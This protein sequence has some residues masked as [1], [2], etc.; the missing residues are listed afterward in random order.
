MKAPLLLPHLSRAVDRKQGAPPAWQAALARNHALDRAI[1][2]YLIGAHLDDLRALENTNSGKTKA[3]RS[4]PSTSTRAKRTRKTASSARA[5]DRRDREGGSWAD[6]VLHLLTGQVPRGQGGPADA[7]LDAITA[8]VREVTW[9]G[10]GG[11]GLQGRS[12]CGMSPAEAAEV[13]TEA[14]RRLPI[15]APATTFP[16]DLLDDDDDSMVND[17]VPWGS[18]GSEAGTRRAPWPWGPKA[19]PPSAMGAIVALAAALPPA[20]KL[21]AGVEV[22]L[23]VSEEVIAAAK[24]EAAVAAGEAAAASGSVIRGNV[25]T[26]A[27]SSVAA[28]GETHRSVEEAS[29]AAEQAL[30]LYISEYC[31]KDPHLWASVTEYVR[32]DG[33]R[34]EVDGSA[35]ASEDSAGQKLVGALLRRCGDELGGKAFVKA[36]PEELDLM[37]CL[38]EVERNLRG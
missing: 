1:L 36:L 28:V 5:R 32:H 27:S 10:N 16:G 21:L 26:G 12:G 19:V 15:T 3:A 20:G 24:A 2:R 14:K 33:D 7:H 34:Q 6:A 29:R 22:M 37:Q 4:T 9:Q 11:D 17:A 23:Q 25:R 35:F 13:V 38:D 8:L 30:L 18:G 31:G